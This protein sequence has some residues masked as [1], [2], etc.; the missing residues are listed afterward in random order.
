MATG[1]EEA[2]AGLEEAWI[3]HDQRPPKSKA[4]MR[5]RAG[6]ARPRTRISLASAMSIMVLKES[7]TCVRIPWMASLMDVRK[8]WSSLCR[9][10]RATGARDSGELRVTGARA[11]RPLP[12]GD[13]AQLRALLQQT[14][15][16]LGQREGGGGAVR[17]NVG[18]ARV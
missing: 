5:T 6:A 17:S 10:L 1:D 7:L 12:L 11:R 4:T 9:H 15:L 3:V 16:I 14:P 8:S 13:V 18:H 2:R